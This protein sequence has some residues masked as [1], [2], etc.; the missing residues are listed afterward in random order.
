MGTY[1]IT[2]NVPNC[3]DIRRDYVEQQKQRKNKK[4][5]ECKCKCK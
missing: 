2:E 4:E 1:Q 3:A 5:S